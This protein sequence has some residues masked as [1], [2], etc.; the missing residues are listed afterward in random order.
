[1]CKCRETAAHCVEGIAHI[2]QAVMKSEPNVD[3]EVVHAVSDP[4]SLSVLATSF[5]PEWKPSRKVRSHTYSMHIKSIS[6]KTSL[7]SLK[8]TGDGGVQI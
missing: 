3:S 7:Y 2:I 8:I 5:L 1:M 6:R 4:L